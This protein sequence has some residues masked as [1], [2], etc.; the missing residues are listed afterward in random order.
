VETVKFEFDRKGYAYDYAPTLE[1][2]VIAERG[3]FY[4]IHDLSA[5]IKAGQGGGRFAVSIFPDNGEVVDLFPTL[6]F[7]T[8]PEV[9]LF[10]KAIGI[11]FNRE[12]LDVKLFLGEVKEKVNRDDYR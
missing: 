4:C 6:E 1:S 2:D 10:F 5:R 7:Q 3:V 11:S 9:V 8:F 12:S